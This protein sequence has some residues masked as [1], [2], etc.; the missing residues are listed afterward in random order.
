M[1]PPP[2]TNLVLNTVVGGLNAPL[3]FQVPNDGSGRFFV[4]EQA[5]G[6]QQERR[7][8]PLASSR[9]EIAADSIDRRDRGA[10]V[11]QQLFLDSRQLFGDQVVCPEKP[12]VGRARE[13]H[14]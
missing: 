5:G 8:D 3:D 1:M 7:A 11:E 4:V 6:K 14:R 2:P 10:E 12:R 9:G 13:L